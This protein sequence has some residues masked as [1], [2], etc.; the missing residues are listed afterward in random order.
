[1]VA[2]AALERNVDDAGVYDT[3]DLRTDD[4]ICLANI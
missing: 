4:D 1:M 2:Y 3:E